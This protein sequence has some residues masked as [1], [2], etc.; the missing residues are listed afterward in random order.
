MVE[1]LVRHL[2]DQSEQVRVLQSQPWR[3]WRLPSVVFHDHGRLMQP[4]ALQKCIFQLLLHI[5]RVVNLEQRRLIEVKLEVRLGKRNHPLEDL[6]DSVDSWHFMKHRFGLHFFRVKIN[7]D[8]RRYLLGFIFGLFFNN[9]GLLGNFFFGNLRLNWLLLYLFLWFFFLRF[10]PSSIF[11]RL[12]F[13]LLDFFCLWLLSFYWSFS[14]C[15]FFNFYWLF[16]FFRF[17]EFRRL[18]SFRW[19]LNNYGFFWFKC[20][21]NFAWLLNYDRFL[22]LLK[23]FNFWLFIFNWYYFWLIIYLV[24]F[25][26]WL[27]WLRDLNFCMINLWLF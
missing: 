3:R 23:F 27:C 21:L 18:F 24:I 19:F 26:D 9:F 1:P 6:L 2:L 17:L 22:Q 16:N 13:F 7:F 8:L 10:S 11:N 14:L 15:L 25:F 12:R 20:F 5:Q 4:I